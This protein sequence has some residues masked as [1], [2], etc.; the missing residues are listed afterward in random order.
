MGRSSVFALSFSAVVPPA[1]DTGVGLTGVAVVA[2][3]IGA[4][5]VAA[6]VVVELVVEPV[7][8]VLR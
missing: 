6:V 3:G 5:V 8:E 7:V 2:A 1:P 4:G